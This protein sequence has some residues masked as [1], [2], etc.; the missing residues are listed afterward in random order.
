MYLVTRGLVTRGYECVKEEPGS[1]ATDLSSAGDTGGRGTER[2]QNIMAQGEG[3]A[4][5]PAGA[6]Q[7]W[8]VLDPK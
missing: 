5:L 8:L 4:H 2:G 1:L 3:P 7:T 6:Y